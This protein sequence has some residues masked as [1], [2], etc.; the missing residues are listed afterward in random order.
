[1]ENYEWLAWLGGK[2]YA[3]VVEKIDNFYDAS[4][5]FPETANELD[6]K[7]PLNKA[8]LQV[9]EHRGKLERKLDGIQKPKL[10]LV[11]THD[12][13]DH[14]YLSDDNQIIFTDFRY[15]LN[16]L[17]EGDDLNLGLFLINDDIKHREK[18]HVPRGFGTNAR[19]IYIRPKSKKQLIRPVCGPFNHNHTGTLILPFYKLEE[20]HCTP[21]DILNNC[22]K[23]KLTK[24]NMER[25]E[26][27]VS[28]ATQNYLREIEN[29]KV[30]V[31]PHEVDVV[32]SEFIG[33]GLSWREVFS[34]V[35]S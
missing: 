35:F 9:L 16:N 3:Q 31:T 32:Y 13:K 22:E 25:I 11:R 30:G 12:K 34:E 4:N 14:E 29:S 5:R 28:N 24:I 15:K 33:G 19:I 6:S 21:E 17:M 20:V 26:K 10:L 2:G 18:G 27:L 23:Q 8:D 1:M 7:L